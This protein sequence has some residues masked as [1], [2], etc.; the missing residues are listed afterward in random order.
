MISFD[1]TYKQILSTACL[2]CLDPYFQPANRSLPNVGCCSYSPVFTLF[3]LNACLMN[4][5]EAFFR[6]RIFANKDA[7]IHDF[8][9]IVH[10]KV[11]D[12]FYTTDVTSLSKIEIDDVK[13]GYSVCQFFKKGAGCQLYPSYKNATCRS[14]ICMAIEENLTDIEQKR[15][16]ESAKNIQEEVKAFNRCYTKLFQRK[17]WNFHRYLDEIIAYFQKRF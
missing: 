6:E 4:N 9:V 2:N 17:G 5:D 12:A 16:S 1:K 10:A 14:F 8:E 11:N 15:L 7:S 13:L 3:E